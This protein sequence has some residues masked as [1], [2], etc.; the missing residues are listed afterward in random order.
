MTVVY[1]QLRPNDGPAAEAIAG[2][3]YPHLAEEHRM[4]ARDAAVHAN[5]FPAG[6]LAAAVDGHL[7]GMALGWLMDFDLEAPAH[8]LDDVAP[9][10]RHDPDG[11]WYYGLEIAVDPAA[12][13]R[14]IGRGLYRARKALVRRLGRRGI[15]AGG[16]IPGYRGI[17]DQLSPERYVAEVVEGRRRDPTLSFQLSN[18]FRVHGVLP[19]YVTGTA[20]G[21]IATLLVWRNPDRT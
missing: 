10:H 15:I 6:A 5:V 9:A 4:H 18:G 12:R 1:R 3:C 19:G 7:A 8:T 2:R 20:G 14:G 16:M 17:G 21:G 13:G 11:D